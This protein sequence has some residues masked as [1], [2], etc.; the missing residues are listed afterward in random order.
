MYAKILV[1]LDGSKYS[2]VGGRI[3]LDLAKRLGS[4]IIASHVYDA[5]IHSSRFQEMEPVLPSRYQD[6]DYLS[7]LRR[8]HDGLIFE[9]FDSLSRGYIEDFV[10][11][12]GKEGVFITEVHREGRNYAEL[13]RIAEEQGAN[14]I[15][16]GA[17]GL[18]D[19]KD[20]IL[21]STALR[22]LRLASCDVFIAR[23]MLRGGNV[24]VGIDGSQDALLS[25]RKAIIWSRS[26]GKNLKLAAAYDPKFH[27][28]VFTA[29]ADSLSP[30]RQE[31]V[32]LSKQE[33]L[34]KQIIDDGLGKLYKS[35]LDQALESCRQVK[36][37][38]EAVLLQG[39]AY[40]SLIDHAGNDAD[41]IVA[42]RFGHHRQ[43][44][45]EIGS[46]S[47]ALA[48]LAPTNVLITE[49]LKSDK[50]HITA[51]QEKLEWEQEALD[52]LNKIPPFA[53]SMAKSGV[54]RFIRAKGG[55]KVTLQEFNELAESLGMTPPKDKKD[56]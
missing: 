51:T 53:R 10:S 44:M 45:V 33:E 52:R 46:N 4:E 32:G 34:H 15:V 3:A 6:E 22:V 54:E 5:Q 50:Q 35:F 49:P 20:G 25:L 14:L 24:L 47:E 1:A 19:A 2:V 31:E 11:T 8:S 26:F 28:Q 38:P 40:K 27:V 39:K 17:H 30:E 48:Q 21:G 55:T 56:E 37:M 9:G 29:M 42:G 18:G 23:Q 36:P 7:D 16:M 13:I 43:E 12:A 41:L